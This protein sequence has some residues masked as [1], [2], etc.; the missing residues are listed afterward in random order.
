VLVVCESL[1][2][3]LLLCEQRYRSCSLPMPRGRKFECV[4]LLIRAS[5]TRTQWRVHAPRCSELHFQAADMMGKI[6]PEMCVNV[7]M[8]VCDAIVPKVASTSR[9][10]PCLGPAL[11]PKWG[12][13]TELAA[14][15]S[16]K[17]QN[18]SPGTR[19]T[20]LLSSCAISP[21]PSFPRS[22]DL[23]AVRNHDGLGRRAALGAHLL[24]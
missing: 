13:C 6:L 4:H 3:P 10:L 2:P 16:L 22:R 5:T 19:S 8:C 14:A 17:P 11:E 23:A 9:F 1:I 24:D 21:D 20:V 18:K 15:L 7:C 12:F